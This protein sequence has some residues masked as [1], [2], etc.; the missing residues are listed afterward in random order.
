[1]WVVAV[2]Q[3]G[4]AVREHRGEP[5]MEL[6]VAGVQ[7]STGVEEAVEKLIT[8]RVRLAAK[9]DADTEEDADMRKAVV[10]GDGHRGTRLGTFLED[11]NSNGELVRGG[12]NGA[13]AFT[14]G[15]QGST[16]VADPFGMLV[17]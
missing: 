11:R 4:D 17:A 12:S 16:R 5:E 2:D 6:V 3:F 9:K 14:R 13:A 1:M 7:G 8:R 15:G 10:D